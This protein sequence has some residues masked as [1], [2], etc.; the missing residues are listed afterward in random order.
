MHGNHEVS[1]EYDM[2]QHVMN[3]EA[4]NTCEGVQDVHALILGSGIDKMQAFR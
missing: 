4:I 3:L 1:D 2:I